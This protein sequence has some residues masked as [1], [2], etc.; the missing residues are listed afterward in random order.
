M[1][2]DNI[3]IVMVIAHNT[4]GMGKYKP[5]PSPNDQQSAY[6]QT[7]VPTTYNVPTLRIKTK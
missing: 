1:S 4:H 6:N 3:V 7:I 2:W 5:P